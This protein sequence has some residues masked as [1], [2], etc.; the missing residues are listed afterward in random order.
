MELPGVHESPAEEN[1]SQPGGLLLSE[2]NPLNKIEDERGF[3]DLGRMSVLAY[4]GALLEADGETELAWTATVALFAGM[5]KG[6]TDWKE[7]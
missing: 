6:G 2:D 7:Q 3:L 5:F 4:K 1:S